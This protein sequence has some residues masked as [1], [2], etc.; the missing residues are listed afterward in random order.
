MTEIPK[1]GEHRIFKGGGGGAY[2]G[3]S[4]SSH[5]C[6]STVVTKSSRSLVQARLALARSLDDSWSAVRALFRQT[7]ATFVNLFMS[8]EICGPENERGESTKEW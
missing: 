2:L 7:A 6:M 3:C 1:G 4:S 8:E 5:S